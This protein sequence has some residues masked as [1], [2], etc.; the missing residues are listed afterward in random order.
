MF[1]EELKLGVFEVFVR[2]STWGCGGGGTIVAF[3]V[4]IGEFNLSWVS[5]CPVWNVLR[6]SGARGSC[7]M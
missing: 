4:R 5:N 3:F 1:L 6:M 7:E 2:V